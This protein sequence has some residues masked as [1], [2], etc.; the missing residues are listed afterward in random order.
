LKQITIF[1]HQNAI[2]F[3][4]YS[5]IY[6]HSRIKKTIEEMY[7]KQAFAIG[8]T[9]DEMPVGFLTVVNQE[10][11]KWRC[12][13][14]FIRQEHRNLG[15]GKQLVAELCHLAQKEGVQAV[16]F[17][18]MEKGA[19][20]K[21]FL[22][23][24]NTFGFKPSGCSR[25]V[26]ITPIREIEKFKM[27]VDKKYA[28]YL[29]MN[30]GKVIKRFCELTEGEIEQLK[31]EKGIQY[32]EN[33]YPFRSEDV[34]MTHSRI[35]FKNKDPAAWIAYRILGTSA[36]YVDRFFIKERYRSHGLF[37]PLFYYTY[38]TTP[39]TI[40]KLVLYIKG[41]NTS[42]LSLFRVFKDCDK[43]EDTMIELIKAF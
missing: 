23:I 26:F 8:L 28:R 13:G 37:F 2:A 40:N 17:R 7:S 3:L 12:D 22:A 43:V 41:H 36:I 30:G 18:Y 19:T 20:T 29:E 11:E 21:P 15:Y 1:N 6:D 27:M 14:P 33:F 38:I 24:M 16:Y 39:E 34:D 25:K 35:I 31:T 32:P 4:D 5:R 42:M 9:I 10:P